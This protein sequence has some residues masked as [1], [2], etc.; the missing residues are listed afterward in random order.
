[1]DIVYNTH[2][3]GA[4][5]RTYK[6]KTDAGV[7][8][9]Y[10]DS[11]K[12]TSI[13]WTKET[14]GTLLDKERPARILSNQP[15]NRLICCK[16]NDI[17]ANVNWPLLAQKDHFWQT[18]PSIAPAQEMNLVTTVFQ[19][20]WVGPHHRHKLASQQD[21][22]LCLCYCLLW[23][24]PSLLSDTSTRRKFSLRYF[25]FWYLN[26]SKGMVLEKF[27]RIFLTAFSG[28]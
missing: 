2:V 28:G 24:K 4:D 16:K 6:V 10:T 13:S 27:F 12:L 5:M 15:A 18:S 14:N 25:I 17:I 22:S 26:A 20:S 1:M 11:A 21:V 8:Y 3:L 19:G 7:L 23:H 9:R